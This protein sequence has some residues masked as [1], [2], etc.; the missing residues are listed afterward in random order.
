MSNDANYLSTSQTA[1]IGIGNSTLRSSDDDNP[2]PFRILDQLAA[3]RMAVDEKVSQLIGRLAP[4]RDDRPVPVEGTPAEMRDVKIE[5]AS[6]LE[7]R[8][9]KETD[10]LME[11][12]DSLRNLLD[13][14]RL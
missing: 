8:I 4:Y 1:A 9:E 13:G 2:P 6:P 3:A 5:A 12:S 14:L 10:Q 7:R 11:I